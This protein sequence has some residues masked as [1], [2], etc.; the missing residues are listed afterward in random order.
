MTPCLNFRMMEAKIEA[1]IE[2]GIQEE[3]QMD[4]QSWIAWIQ[5][6]LELQL[7][8]DFYPFRCKMQLEVPEWTLC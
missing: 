4:I 1:K 2:A 6:K 3:S 8:I 7:S 5:L